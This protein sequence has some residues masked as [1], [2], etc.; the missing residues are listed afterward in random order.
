MPYQGP[1]MEKEAYS[2][3]LDLSSSYWTTYLVLYILYLVNRRLELRIAGEAEDLGVEDE[4]LCVLM[5]LFIGEWKAD[6][7]IVRSFLIFLN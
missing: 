5:F 7:G 6:P 2:D 1:H 4:L 3:Y